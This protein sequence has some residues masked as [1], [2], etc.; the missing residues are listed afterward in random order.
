M[1]SPA[2]LAPSEQ[3]PRWRTWLETG[4]ILVALLLFSLWLSR[5]MLSRGETAPTEHLP[6]LTTQAA[7]AVLSWP[8]EEKT[9]VYFFAPW[10]SVCRVSMPSLNLLPDAQLR[11][12]AIALDW[13]T[14][15]EVREFV[16]RSG[17]T[18]DVMLGNPDVARRWQIDAYPSYYV[19]AAD[20]RILHRDRGLSTP[21]GLWLRTL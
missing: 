6:L 9:L 15:G 19:I 7:T 14:E 10:C 16:T 4:L 20:G 21:P 18:G 3:R 17:Y 2:S 8:A 1:N 12:V 13:Q 5:D 11:V